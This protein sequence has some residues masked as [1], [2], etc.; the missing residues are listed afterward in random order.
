MR[1]VEEDD[2]VRAVSSCTALTSLTLG[3][4]DKVTDA[5][6]RALSSLPALTFLNLRNCVKVTDQ[7]RTIR[8]R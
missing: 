2:G 3:L 4:C 7:K 1:W 6:L 8:V 5:G